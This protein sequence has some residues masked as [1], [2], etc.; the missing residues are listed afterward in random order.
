MM[1]TRKKCISSDKNIYKKFIENIKHNWGI[2][3]IF[4]LKVRSMT[5]IAVITTSIQQYTRCPK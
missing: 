1:Q 5:S 2:I 3:E 4:V